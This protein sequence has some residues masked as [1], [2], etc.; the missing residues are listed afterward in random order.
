MELP[1]MSEKRSVPTYASRSILMRAAVPIAAL[2]CVAGSGVAFAAPESVDLLIKTTLQLEPD[3]ERGAKLYGAHCQSC[4]GDGAMGSAA[5]LIPALA[6]QRRAYLI[7]Q[8]ADFA[9]HERA[10]TQMHVVVARR[11]VGEPQEW[12][13]LTAYLNGLRVTSLPQIG[14]GTYLA[15][16][17][18]SYERWCVSCHGEDGRGDDDG[19]APSLRNQHYA[20]LLHQMREWSNGHRMNVDADLVRFMKTLGGDE[21]T[22]LADY[23]ARLHGPVRDR[24]RLRDDGTAGD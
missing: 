2:L 12:A 4:H 8:L 24:A 20:Y 3:V 10:A 21:M 18:A 17:E 23:I 19:F 5:K 14:N 9:E 22:G 13:D 11:E 6:K 15:L 16:G 7:K 1:M